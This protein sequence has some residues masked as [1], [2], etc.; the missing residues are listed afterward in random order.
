MFPWSSQNLL[1]KGLLAANIN[2]SPALTYSPS[3]VIH[4]MIYI[5]SSITYSHNQQREADI[6]WFRASANLDG[7]WAVQLNVQSTHKY[8]VVVEHPALTANTAQHRPPSSAPSLSVFHMWTFSQK[9]KKKYYKY[10]KCFM[11]A[12]QLCS[13][14]NNSSL[15]LFS[16][17]WVKQPLKP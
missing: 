7:F 1:W 8:V 12:F 5:S 13:K 2:V 10:I 11:Y 9:K 16:F 3:V 6:V 14:Y 15:L 17:H 4:N